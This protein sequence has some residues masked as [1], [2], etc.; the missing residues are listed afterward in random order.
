[1]DGAG[2]SAGDVLFLF[3]KCG[4][5]V[6]GD[7]HEDAV[8]DFSH[9]TGDFVLFGFGHVAADY[10]PALDFGLIDPVAD[11]GFRVV[12]EFPRVDEAG[13]AVG[14]FKAVG[15]GQ[16]FAV[17]SEGGRVDGAG[18]VGGLF[19]ALGVGVGVDFD[20]LVAGVAGREL[21]GVSGL[22]GDRFEV[23]FGFRHWMGAPD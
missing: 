9:P 20:L 16:D 23:R 11:V 13:L 2:T 3:D 10:L 7:S 1:M 18:G 4:V 19:D 22:A 14:D 8:A 21:A 5:A 17:G 6:D 15:V 12:K